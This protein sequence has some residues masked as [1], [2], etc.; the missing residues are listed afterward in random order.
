[1]DICLSPRGDWRKKGQAGKA[2]HLPY[3]QPVLYQPSFK[4]PGTV[5]LFPTAPSTGHRNTGPSVG[6][7]NL[8][9][10]SEMAGPTR[11]SPMLG[12]GGDMSRDVASNRIGGKLNEQDRVK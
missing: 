5:F 2:L 1:M 10:M 9:H 3:F 8:G 11:G 7:T 12:V 4:S 6:P